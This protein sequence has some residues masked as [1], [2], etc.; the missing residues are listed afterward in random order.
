MK[1]WNISRRYYVSPGDL[2]DI[3][4]R[5]WIRRIWAFQE[6][7]LASNPVI[8]CGAKHLPWSR[9]TLSI[10]FINSTENI[11][12]FFS[13]TP[14]TLSWRG[15]LFSRAQLSESNA[16]PH[17]ISE[18]SERYLSYRRFVVSMNQHYLLIRRLEAAALLVPYIT[19]FALGFG[20]VHW[21]K[22]DY[23]RT[24]LHHRSFWFTT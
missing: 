18:S 13:T 6:I 4:E 23:D 19:C 14:S 15:I 8:V 22:H 12:S 5:E 3:L 11:S 20:L 21:W 7:L 10:I 2:N 9:F 17:G 24:K 16:N 1:I